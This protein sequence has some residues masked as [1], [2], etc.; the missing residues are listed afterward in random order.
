MKI[1][2]KMDTRSTKMAIRNVRKYQERLQKACRQY[3]EELA[4]LGIKVAK[5]NEGAYAGKIL[6]DKKIEPKAHGCTCIMIAEG[7]EIER[8][9]K[10]KGGIQTANVNA[11]LMSEF[12]S[13]WLADNDMAKE[14]GANAGQG[15][16]PD[17]KHAF[18]TR[19]WWWT[20]EDGITHHHSFGEE[21]TYPMYNAYLEMYQQMNTIAK[22]VFSEVLRYG[23]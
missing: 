16:F 11:L 1:N 7:A 13:G 6:Y 18:D 19:G 12:G 22:K 14:W 2:I 15:T 9:W 3:V 21:P 10:T 17:Q 8:K 20:D 23:K 5:G 4:N